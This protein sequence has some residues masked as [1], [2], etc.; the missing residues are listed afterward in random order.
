MH[1]LRKGKGV[2]EMGKV[3]NQN[4]LEAAN[5]HIPWLH[6]AYSLF[7]VTV[8]NDCANISLQTVVSATKKRNEEC[9]IGTDNWRTPL[10]E[11]RRLRWKDRQ[12]K[13]WERGLYVEDRGKDWLKYPR[14]G[15]GCEA[16]GIMTL[17]GAE[18]RPVWLELRDKAEDVSYEARGI[19]EAR[20]NM[21]PKAFVRCLIFIPWEDGIIERS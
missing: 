1:A 21:A 16:K 2:R 9:A 19:R 18:R 8:I 13:L 10:Y 5:R 4:P 12:D 6:G 15:T 7:E 20:R 3:G 17:R 14:W 11:Q